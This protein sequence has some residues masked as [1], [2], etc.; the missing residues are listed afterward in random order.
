MTASL[1]LSVLVL[2]LGGCQSEL[3]LFYGRIDVAGRERIPPTG[4]R[5]AATVREP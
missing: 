4:P 3:R 2:L 5:L 1:V